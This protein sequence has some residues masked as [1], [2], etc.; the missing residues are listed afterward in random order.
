VVAH[1][2]MHG[3]LGDGT[4]IDSNVFDYPIT[5]CWG[6]LYRVSTFDCQDLTT[7]SD[8]RAPCYIGQDD[9]VDCRFAAIF[10]WDTNQL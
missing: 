1:V 7:S 5:I 3:V 8:M 4:Q 9:G 10:G 6:C 2:R